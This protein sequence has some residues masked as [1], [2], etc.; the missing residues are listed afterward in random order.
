MPPPG[1]PGPF[2]LADADALAG[3]LAAAG[4]ADVVVSERPV[5][6]RADSFDEWW[7]RTSALAGPLTKILASMP[8]EAAQA[9]RARARAAAGAYETPVGLEFPGVTLI[10]SGSVQRVLNSLG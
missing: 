8:E 4:L 1:V 10:A 6:L 9:I 2:S 3:L 7:E 5:P